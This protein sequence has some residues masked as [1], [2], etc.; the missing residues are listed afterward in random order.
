VGLIAVA[1]GQMRHD[2]YGAA[3]SGRRMERGELV[4]RFERWLA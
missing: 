4:A 3:A 2:A 1:A